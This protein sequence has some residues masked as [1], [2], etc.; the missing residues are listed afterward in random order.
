MD[1]PNTGA[2]TCRWAEPTLF[3]PAPFWFEAESSP[4]TCVREAIP[5]VLPT[6]VKCAD[7]A[8]WQPRTPR[9]SAP[10]AVDWFSASPLPHEMLDLRD[11][12][13]SRRQSGS[14]GLGV[15]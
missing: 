10:P 9:R 7:C 5:N 4:W 13:M 1:L 8:R 6:T 11:H 12:A 3:M 15:V 2:V 14:G